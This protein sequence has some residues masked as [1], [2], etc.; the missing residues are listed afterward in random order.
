MKMKKNS[1][2]QLLI[3]FLWLGVMSSSAELSPAAP[4]KSG[5]RPKFQSKIHIP[6]KLAKE[7]TPLP[8]P[9]YQLVFSDEFDGGSL[10][11][12]RWGF[13]LES[14]MLSTQ[15]REN[16]SV[17]DGNLVIALRK[18]SVRGK[19]YTGGGVISRPTFVYGYY[20]ARF[21]TPPAEGWHTSFW[22]MK[23]NFPVPS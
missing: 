21:K 18:E 14:K 8:P 9:G 5:E 1:G 12:N 7:V 23:K 22:A 10:N 2:N 6:V 4:A 3:A 11:T 16:V 20:E 13:R 15:Q 17:K 19:N